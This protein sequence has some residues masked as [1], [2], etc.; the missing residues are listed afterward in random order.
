VARTRTRRFMPLSNRLTRV[1][2]SPGSIREPVAK[3]GVVRIPFPSSL[4]ALSN[5]GNWRDHPRGGRCNAGK[6]SA[7]YRFR[8]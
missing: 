1:T 5:P 2:R 3:S 8:I 6:L 4:S 7:L